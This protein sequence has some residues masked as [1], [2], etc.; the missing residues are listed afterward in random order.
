MRRSHCGRLVAFAGS[1]AI[2]SA[3]SDEVRMTFMPVNRRYNM[4]QLLSAPR[5]GA[6]DKCA[7][8]FGN[9]RAAPG[10][11]AADSAQGERVD[12]KRGA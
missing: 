12:K 5:L 2:C 11:D 9:L 1:L 3:S 8:E 6:S 7:G 4:G 10:G